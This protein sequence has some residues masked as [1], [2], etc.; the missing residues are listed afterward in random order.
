MYN[1]T[2]LLRRNLLTVFLLGSIAVCQTSESPRPGTFEGQDATV[3][4]NGSLELTVLTQGSIVASIVITDGGEKLNPLWN[5]LRLARDAGRT[6]VFN[7]T[8]GHFVCV[9]GF[10]QSSAEERAAGLLQHGEAHVTR[11]HVTNDAAGNSISLNATLPIVQ[12]TFSRT[13]HM[14][15]GESVIY[16]DSQLESLLGFDRPV[17]WAEHATVA[18]PFLEPGQTTIAIS[19][20]RS[21]NR[22]YLANQAGR[23]GRGGNAG[24]GNAP[25]TQRRLVS[26]K[27][28]TWPMADGLDGKSVDMS[29]IPDNPHF[30]DHAATL[31][32]PA[33]RLEWVTVLN[34]GKKLIYGYVFRRE[35]YPWLQHW[36]NFPSGAALVRGLEFATQPYDVPRRDAISAN[37][38]FG[39]PT[40]RWLPAKSKIESHFLIFYARVPDG[41]RKVDNVTLE[42]G[43]IVIEDHGDAKQIVLAASRGL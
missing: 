36:G 39:T 1:H 24:R 27:D 23:G 21:Q 43:A 25:A 35:D 28:F 13:F 31:L 40:Y 14:A 20:T 12:E 29:T 33:R 41:F 15:P 5:P 16:V 18:A 42:N 22:D 17:N 9:D 34:S 8:L 6:A 11:F 10:G 4:S 7:G 38:L 19:G 37:S 2:S 30:I 3:L 32:D 26:G